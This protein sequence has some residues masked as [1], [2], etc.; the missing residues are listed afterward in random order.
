MSNRRKIQPPARVQPDIGPAMLRGEK[1]NT[2]TVLWPKGRPELTVL[3]PEALEALVAAHNDA[4][5]AL[6]AAPAAPKRRRSLLAFL[7]GDR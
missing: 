4:V 3:P 7:R 6:P 5:R 2:L 1:D